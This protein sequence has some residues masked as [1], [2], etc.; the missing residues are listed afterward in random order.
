MA[1]MLIA[2]TPTADP[3]L[4]GSCHR[5]PER[6]S[7]SNAPPTCVVTTHGSLVEMMRTELE[8]MTPQVGCSTVTGWVVVD[9][10]V[11]AYADI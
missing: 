10:E 2:D 8:G 9:T 11:V 7:T 5:N 4:T 6:S 3:L 1:A